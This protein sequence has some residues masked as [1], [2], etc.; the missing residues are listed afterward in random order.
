MK[1]IKLAGLGCIFT[2]YITEMSEP[3]NVSDLETDFSH[4]TFLLLN[5]FPLMF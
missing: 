4:L 1:C 3:F 2:Y 5:N